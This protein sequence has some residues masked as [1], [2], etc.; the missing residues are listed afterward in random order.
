MSNNEETFK[1][2]LRSKYK[3]TSSFVTGLTLF[4]FD[5]LALMISIG[6]GF[7][8]INF[9]DPSSI[10]FRSFIKYS[11]FMPFAAVA[12][13]AAGL[14]PGILL[15]PEDEVKKFSTCSFLCLMGM[16]LAITTIKSTRDFIPIALALVTAWPFATLFLP[17]FREWAR[18]CSCKFSWWGVPAVIYTHGNNGHEIVKRLVEH[19]N[20][21]YIPILIITDDKDAS[22]TFMDIPVRVINDQI[23]QILSELK[24]KVAI[25]CDYKND[26]EAIQTRYRYM[27]RVPRNQLAT[28]LSLKMKNF[29]GIL[30][31]SSTNYLTKFGSLLLKR[32]IDILLCLSVAPFAIP[33]GIFCALGIKLTSKGPVFYGHKRVG[34]NHK[35]LKCWKFRSMCIDADEKLKKILAEDPV[36]A[37]EWEKDRKFTDDPR[38]T[39][40]GKFL[41]KTSLDELPQL[42]NIFTGSMSFVGPRP[43]T[44]SELSKYGKYSDYVLS[45]TPG[46]SGMWQISGRSDTGYEERISLDT[47]YIQNWSIW[48]DIWIIIK[49]VWVVLKRKGAY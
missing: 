48:L 10:N 37:A 34:Q 49:T 24:I 28:T 33:V 46:L 30:G 19:P 27:I 20:F 26:L 14:Y 40:F 6:A 43:V 39:K 17:L 18:R 29:G 4:F 9:I 36:R 2:Q 16:A 25:V 47:Y 35:L 42:W 5:A 8:I 13:Y 21:G 3:Y 15:A 11:I 41:R 31:F 1:T 23:K 32:T 38:V 7:F 22:D 12:F 45:V 44:E